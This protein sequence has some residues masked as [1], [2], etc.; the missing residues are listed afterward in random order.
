MAVVLYSQRFD[1][2]IC[3]IDWEGSF[4]DTNG[5][6]SSGFHFHVWDAAAMNCERL[7]LALPDFRPRTEL[8]FIEM[9]FLGNGG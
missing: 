7:K 4:V 2:R 5:S 6:Q 9:G 8:E 1:G 3:C